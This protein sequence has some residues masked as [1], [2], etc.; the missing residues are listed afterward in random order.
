MKEHP[1]VFIRFFIK[2]DFLVKSETKL[3]SFLH[4]K[5]KS[6]KEFFLVLPESIIIDFQSPYS[7][8]LTL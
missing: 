5:H 8:Y 1:A 3:H 6:K 7:S 2:N 4:L